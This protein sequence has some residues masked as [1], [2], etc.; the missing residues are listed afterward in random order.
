MQ[1]FGSFQPQYP[2]DFA[3]YNPSAQY[4]YPASTHPQ[5]AT[6]F[7]VNRFGNG[8][9][10]SIGLTTTPQ[11]IMGISVGRRKRRVLFSPQQVN[12]LERRFRA[13][14]YLS[15]QDRE[16]LARSIS[17]TPTQ[18]K[19]WFQNQRYKHK[20]QEK[21]RRM[22]GNGKY[23]DSDDGG[24]ESPIS[25]GSGACSPS[26]NRMKIEKDDEEKPCHVFT[27]P[28]TNDAACLPDLSQ[29]S[30]PYQV[31]PQNTYMPQGFAFAYPTPATYPPPQCFGNFQRL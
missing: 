27:S 22:D 25:H 10:L 9:Q 6:K 18:V 21:E 11:N 2:S 4:L 23:V 24:S 3:S 28:V 20:R 1:Y 29:Q 8:N 7:S 31:Y 30:F 16:V 14:K 19:I 12:E 15:A 26:F 17:L 13:S 5:F